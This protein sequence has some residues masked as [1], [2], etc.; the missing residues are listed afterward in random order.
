MPFDIDTVVASLSR[1]DRVALL[2]GVDNWH[3]AHVPGVGQLRC[4]DGPAGVR[5]TSWRGPASTSFPCGTALGATWDPQLVESVGR[6][7][8]VESR[9]KGAHVLLA[10]TVNLHRT[11]IGGRNF[12]CMSEDPV[13]TAHLARAYVRGVQSEGVGCCIKHFVGNDTEYERMTISSDIDERTLREMYLVPFE[14]ACRP[15]ADGGAGVMA[16]MT[17]YNRLNG[18]FCSESSALLRDVLRADWGWDGVVF[19]DW[20]GTHSTVE[21][22][23]AGLDLEMPGP[24]KWRGA[25]LLDAVGAGEV[26]EALIDD[27][28][29]RLLRLFQA[30]GVGLQPSVEV[31]DDSPTTR[32]TIRDAAVASTVLL[33]N[34]RLLLP[35]ATTTR[36]ALIGP[37]SE[38]GQVQGG[39]SARVRVH[40]PVGPLAALRERGIDV[41]HEV[42]CL[43]DKYLP[44][45]RGAFRMELDDGDGGRVVDDVTTTRFMW[46]DDPA[47][48]ISL[49]YFGARLTGSF[50]PPR[51]G[52]WQFSLAAVG[53]AVLRVNG[54]VLIDLTEAQVGGL[55]FGLGSTEIRAAITLPAG[56]PVTIDAHYLPVPTATLRGFQVGAAPESGTD[57]IAEAVAAAAANDVAVVVVGTD[58]NWETEGEDRTSMALPGAQDELI[59]RVAAA[60]PNTVVVIN[61]GSP[62]LMPWFDDV[63][64][65]MQVWFPG[66]EFGNALADILLGDVEPG[67]RLPVTIPARLSDTPASEYYPGSGGHAV[68]GEGQFIGY[69]WYEAQAIRPVAPF[70]FGLGYTEWQIGSS[71][72]EVGASGLSDGVT[73]ATELANV[74]GRRGGTI[75]QCYVEAPDGDPERPRRSLA[76]FVKVHADA[77][78]QASATLWLPER[79]FSVWDV[80]ARGWIVPPGEYLIHVGTSSAD[81]VVVGSIAAA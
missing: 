63:A 28:V 21:A 81:T 34:E 77:G 67:G 41:T 56:V 69:R 45:V 8:G 13:L 35:L 33:R 10:P 76:A 53:P 39:G 47:P 66:A 3:T 74:G 55:Y 59:R 80:D 4:S 11:P 38:R 48:N 57:T 54:E 32:A 43:I 24:P 68:Y 44:A 78:A 73:V 18:T 17:G 7:L 5:G 75:L 58:A 22:V 51:G 30:T 50:V 61:A 64:A 62:V 12:E 20:F 6:A 19:S 71:T 16:V 31:T 36:V 70:G 52:P 29:R 72:V 14:V 37:N 49:T 27:S 1:D 40:Q 60:N 42:G 15:V 23:E 79:A 46:Q 9:S 25:A 65:V 2:A 26:S